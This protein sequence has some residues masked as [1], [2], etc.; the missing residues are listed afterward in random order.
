MSALTWILMGKRFQWEDGQCLQTP[1]FAFVRQT[2]FS[3]VTWVSI[4][5]LQ[6]L[7]DIACACHI[8]RFLSQSEF[9]PDSP[10]LPKWFFRNCAYIKL[11]LPWTVYA[12][13]QV[14]IGIDWFVQLQN[15]WEKRTTTSAQSVLNLRH[16]GR[17]WKPPKTIRAVLLENKSNNM[18][19]LTCSISPK[20]KCKRV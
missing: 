19:N 8:I 10:R 9:H 1:L 20:L 13:W 18:Q 12:L 6:T 17:A 2:P 4:F 3:S 14:Q 15:L 7:S 5:P 11:S 16:T